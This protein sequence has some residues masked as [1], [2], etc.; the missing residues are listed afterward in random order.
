MV[1][2]I[3]QNVSDQIDCEIEQH[4]RICLF[5]IHIPIFRKIVYALF[6]KYLRYCFFLNSYISR[7][8]ILSQNPENRQTDLYSDFI[9]KLKR[10]I[11]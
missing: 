2:L 10:F 8:I 11:R 6:N 4:S 9:L 5:S 3:G 1:K 7:N